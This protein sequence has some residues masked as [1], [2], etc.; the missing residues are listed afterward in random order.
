MSD[1]K[2][3]LVEAE[4]AFD[5]GQFQPPHRRHLTY[6]Y[7]TE[8]LEAVNPYFDDPNIDKEA[9]IQGVLGTL[10]SSPFPT[11]NPDDSLQ[12]MTLLTPK[13]VPPWP[14]PTIPPFPPQP[15]DPGL[16]V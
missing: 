13:S 9:A 2:H 1:A 5:A 12:R 4:K 11:P 10:F 8:Q 15:S 6:L 3:E 7:Y 14:T 16:S